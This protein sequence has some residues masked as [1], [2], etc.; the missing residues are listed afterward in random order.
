MSHFTKDFIA[1]FKDL[2]KNNDRDWFIENKGRFI[3]NVKEPFERLTG[4]LLEAMHKYDPNILMTAK[5]AIFRIYRDV[6]FSKDKTPYKTH[7]SAMIS[8]GGRKDMTY[9][10]IYFQA[11]AQDIRIYSGVYSPDKKQLEAIR[12]AIALNP[13]ALDKLRSRKAF[14]EKFRGE[15]LGDKNKRLPKEFVEAAE[16]QELIYN[17]SFYY[18][19]KLK[20]S[21]ILD[22]KLVSNVMAHFKAA[23]PINQFFKEA[24]NFD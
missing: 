24:L 19:A 23:E 6:R 20:P 12:T 15:I 13:K 16:A 7:M 8:R 11:G 5:D 21:E 22:S 14:Q 18:Y 10:G 17:K 9:P 3:K 4:D 2:E 1:F